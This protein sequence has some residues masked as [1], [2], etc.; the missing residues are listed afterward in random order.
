MKTEYEIHQK[1]LLEQAQYKFCRT[2]LSETT[3]AAYMANP[4]HLFV[5]RYRK[6][7][8]KEWCEIN[9][10]NLVEHLATLYFDGPLCLFGDDDQDDDR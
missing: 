6:W 2:P 3:Q 8:T 4:R 1:K 5:K 7:G 9:E 10:S